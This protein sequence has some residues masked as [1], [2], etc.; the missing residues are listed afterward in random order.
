MENQKKESIVKGVIL[1]SIPTW[2]NLLLGFLS[3]VV[4]TR[5]LTPDVYGLLNLFLSLSSVLIYIF[6]VGT[7]G[8]YI[9]F[10]NEPPQHNTNSQLLYKNIILS[11]LFCVFFIIVA[12]I[13]GFDHLS[14]L[15]WGLKSELT[16][17]FLFIYTF[18][19]VIM[20]YLNIYYRM[21]FQVKKYNIQNILMN[22]SSRFFILIAA[23]FSND[24]IVV[25]SLLTFGT[26]L[27]TIVYLIIQ[28]QDFTPIDECGVKNYTFS[29]VGFKPY[30]VFALLSAPAY[31]VTYLN[32]YLGQQIVRT[33]LDAYSLGLFTSTGAFTA[34]LASIKGGFSTY[35]SAYTY[36]N[37]NTDRE[38]IGK[39][40]DMV[41]LISILSISALVMLRDCIYLFIGSN[42]HASKSFFSLLLFLPIL[43]FIQE[44][45]D[46]GIAIAKKNQITLFIHIVAVVVNVLFCF[47]LINRYG[48]IG[49]AYSSAISALTLFLLSSYWGQKF[50]RTILSPLKSGL[51]I[52]LLIVVLLIP[53]IY[54]NIIVICIC[55]SIIDIVACFVYKSEI[56]YIFYR[57]CDMIKKFIRNIRNQ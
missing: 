38:R 44:T 10:F 4:L 46:K 48:I 11:V 36:K 19:L 56:K 30:L 26:V 32:T 17:L 49:A 20:R 51:G 54:G 13:I 22:S 28:K 3:I 45:T 5:V 21:S 42:Y 1:Y 37:Y 7:D 16:V 2:V 39:M 50:Y 9:R 25:S 6:T 29:L 34:I 33:S 12:L 31:I 15:F 40:H 52:V 18:S 41:V 47:L 24:F 53:S 57:S 35:W 14:F 43:S 27:L 55:V 8:A 23:L